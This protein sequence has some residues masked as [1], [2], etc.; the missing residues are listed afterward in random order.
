M[1]PASSGRHPFL[2]EF[3]QVIYCDH[4]TGY[5]IGSR[6]YPDVNYTASNSLRNLWQITY[7]YDGGSG[8]TNTETE[9]VKTY[10]FTINKTNDNQTTTLQGAEFKLYND[11][12]GGTPVKFVKLSDT[13]YRIAVSTDAASDCV[14]VIP[15]GM[16]LQVITN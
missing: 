15:A 13:M 4:E 7:N 8:N 2:K 6:N 9:T 11:P 16:R 14:E 5:A 3:R 1:Y 12:T 10:G